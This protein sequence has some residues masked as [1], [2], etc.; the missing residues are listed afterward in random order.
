VSETA[1]AAL[2]A[3]GVDALSRPEALPVSLLLAAVALLLAARRRPERLGWG[4]PQQAAAAGAR[5]RDPLRGLCLALRGGALAALALVLAGPVGVHRAP[6][7][8]G[9]GLDLVLVLDASGSM[10]ALDARG[11]DG[12]RTRLD[13]AREVVGRFAARRAAEGDRVALVVFG[14]SAFTLCPLT[15]DAALL[16][17]ALSRVEPGMA[18][19]ATAL[20]DALGLAV[21]RAA[22]AGGDA[23]AAGRVAVLL[24]D[25][26]HNAG[27]LSMEVATAL[28]AAEGLRVHAV[29]IGSAEGPVAMR[30]PAAGAGRGLRFERHEVDP[31]TLRNVSLATGGRFFRARRSGDLEA[32][33]A[34][35]DSLERLE[36]P[37]PSRLR[38]TERP[39]PLLALAGGLLLG[40]V[41]LARVLRRRLP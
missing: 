16:E 32:V 20:G 36:R 31:A 37:L 11:P 25:G 18:G 19:E 2:G 27:A 4:A 34:A 23:G 14:E 28:A 1:A 41:T 38:H 39:Q 33:Y 35:I 30:P 10:R 3:L 26:R 12:W 40:E 29:A 9:L 22:A 6:P 17:A 8:P 24:S 15:S 7:Q 13:L 21:K 5:R